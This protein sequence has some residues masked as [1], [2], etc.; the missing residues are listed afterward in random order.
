M[1]TYK[2]IESQLVRLQDSRPETAVN[3]DGPSLKTA[4]RYIAAFDANP[5]TDSAVCIENEL[6]RML[7][8]A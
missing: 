4:E 7:A 3:L 8:G 1:I 5:Y 6:Q 2:V